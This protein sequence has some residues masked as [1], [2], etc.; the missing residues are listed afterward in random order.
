MKIY[1]LVILLGVIGFF[2][3]NIVYKKTNSYKNEIKQLEK[4]IN[5]VPENL[6]I[7]NLGSSYAR[8]AFEYKKIGIN[9]F[10]FGLQPQSLSYD[11]RILKQYTKN[12]NK[13]CIVTIVLP[14]L[15]FGFLD[16]KDDRANTKYYYFLEPKYI[17]NYSKIKYFLKMYF[18]L[19]YTP[20]R[21]YRIFKD[22]EK[23]NL[24]QNKNL[25][26]FEEVEKEAKNRV[27]GWEKQFNLKNMQNPEE[28]PE[29]LRK[30]FLQTQS[31]LQEIINY[32]K[33]N[34][35][36]PVLVVPPCSSVLNKLI[37]KDFLNE[38]LYKNNIESKGEA[39]FLDYLNH[40]EFQ[41]Y[42]LYINSDMLNENGRIKFT[43]LFLKDLEKN[44]IKVGE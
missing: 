21:V 32:C 34:K 43:K 27:K 36:S 1:L 37:S 4:F 28:I 17:L 6:D 16:Y 30:I 20:K 22:V 31:L 41:D 40:E 13:N 7:V 8:N 33:E 39:L 3:L 35:F 44:G 15:V 42:K 24:E 10:N 23:I 18:P 9:G 12:L 38:A 29:E 5:G 25:L 19:L 2:I 14:D 11:F 26:T